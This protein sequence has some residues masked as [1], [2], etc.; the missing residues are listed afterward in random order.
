MKEKGWKK[1]KSEGEREVKK[2]EQSSKENEQENERKTEK[3]EK[4]G[5]I[6]AALAAERNTWRLLKRQSGNNG[7]TTRTPYDASGKK[8]W[9]ADQHLQAPAA[10][11]EC[12]CAL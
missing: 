10:G 12:A 11:K 5:D 4:E 6:Q 9:N 3:E 1:N 8:L 7:K 2:N